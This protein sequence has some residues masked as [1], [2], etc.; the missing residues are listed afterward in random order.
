M[1]MILRGA[2]WLA[3]YLLLILFPLIV[4]WLWHS[5]GV[6]G[7]P[8]SLQFSTACGYVALTVMAFE[9]SL[10]SRVGFAAAVFGQDALLQFHRQMGFVA[11]A[12][13]LM[14]VVFVL[15]NGYPLTWLIP[16]SEGSVHWGTLAAYSLVLL[17]LLSLIRKR[18]GISYGWWQVTHSFLANAILAMG[19]V[20][21]LRV[22]SF[23]GPMAM[24]ELWAV[25][26][27]LVIGLVLR[28]R[29][30]KPILMWGR[31]WQ[32]V[33]SRKEAG[34]SRTLVLK[35]VG[36]DGLT[37]E[38]GQFAWLN[39]GKTPFHRDQHPISFSSCASDEPGGEI[40]FTVKALGDWSGTS[41]PRL[42]TG[43]TVWVDGPYGVFSPDREQGPGYVLIAGGIGV[44]PFYS[45]CL[46]F[47]ERGDR[48]PVVLFYAGGTSEDL[49][50]RDQLDSLL[51]RLNLEIVYVL[52]DPAP[53]WTG[54]R[55]Y[56]TAEVLKRHLPKQFKRMQYFVCGPTPMMDAMEK[57]LPGIGVPAECI[58]SERLEMA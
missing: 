16:F 55:G 24:K 39:T 56:V 34:S 20:H 8:F 25:Y 52:T 40:A 57:I 35:P 5:P 9:F 4:G 26:L 14:H 3:C 41:V 13:I 29:L 49:T 47:A 51:G 38:P 32:V 31:R 54:E 19:A 17:I 43:D 12:L 45:M 11:A 37:F 36:H 53:G 42:Q 21:V 28:F 48:R 50:F 7:R 46:T 6:E 27:L 33:E 58:H 15:R 1:R 23:V 44:T 18:L 22:G 10:I 30:L 2:A